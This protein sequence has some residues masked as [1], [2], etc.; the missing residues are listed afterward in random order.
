MQRILGVMKQTLL[1]AVALWAGSFQSH[2]Q[3]STQTNVLVA[4]WNAV[5][6]HVDASHATLNQLVGSDPNNPI[7]EIWYW[8][9]ALPTGQFVESP[10]V[11]SSIGN[12]WVSWTRAAG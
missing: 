2:A 7:Q 6:L 12:Q 10:Q 9:P 4:G 11:P 5:F 1:V 3:W 8:A